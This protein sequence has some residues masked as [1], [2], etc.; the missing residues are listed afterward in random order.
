MIPSLGDASIMVLF[1]FCILS[2]SSCLNTDLK[3]ITVTGE[4][5]ASRMGVT[6]P[7]EHILVDFAS[8]DSLGMNLYNRDSVIAKVLL[9]F[10]EFKEYKV[11]TFVDDM[12]KFMGCDPELLA[13]LSRKPEI[14]IFTN[15]GCHASD[16]ERQLSKE[17]KD[18]SAEDI[19]AVWIVEAKNGIRNTSIKPGIIKPC[20]VS[21]TN[22][23]EILELFIPIQLV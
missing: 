13:Q 22:E 10:E 5:P 19:A 7:N 3:I 14:N 2:V 12:P 6:L 18:M 11:K 15:T 9:Y 1:L 21:I 17:F 8:I 23:F 16:D 4:I 20:F